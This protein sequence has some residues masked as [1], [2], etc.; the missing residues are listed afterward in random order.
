M[1]EEQLAQFDGRTGTTDFAASAKRNCVSAAKT[2]TRDL[3][4]SLIKVINSIYTPRRNYLWEKGSPCRR[5]NS[6]TTTKMW[7]P[8]ARS[9]GSFVVKAIV[10]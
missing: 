7:L 8:T 10:L 6:F 4:L 5:A 1:S 3:R 2:R 9:R